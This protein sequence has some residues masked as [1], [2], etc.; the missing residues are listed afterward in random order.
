MDTLILPIN[1]KINQE[2]SLK[3][4]IMRDCLKYFWDLYY[5]EPIIIEKCVDTS[6]V[7][8]NS[9]RHIITTQK[10]LYLLLGEAVSLAQISVVI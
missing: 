7:I 9:T 6:N 4:L 5:Y 10:I 2:L 3:Y 1:K 8:C